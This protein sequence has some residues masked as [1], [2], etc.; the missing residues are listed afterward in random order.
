MMGG[1]LRLGAQVCRWGTGVQMGQAHGAQVC[2]WGTGVQM[3]HAHVSVLARHIVCTLTRHF[4]G[5]P[6]CQPVVV[7][8]DPCRG[9]VLALRVC[10]WVLCTY[11]RG[12]VPLL[13]QSAV[14]TCV[15]ASWC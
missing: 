12:C 2:T 14:H 9:R 5:A 7:C 4:V 13:G 1:G 10:K 3:G 8:T 11:V 15:S 6:A